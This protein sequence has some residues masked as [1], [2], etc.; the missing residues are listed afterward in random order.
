[1]STAIINNTIYAHAPL[2]RLPHA[3]T[4]SPLVCC[5]CIIIII[6]YAEVVRV[7]VVGVEL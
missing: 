3:H 2:P 1:M 6:I 4:A 5:I 7:R